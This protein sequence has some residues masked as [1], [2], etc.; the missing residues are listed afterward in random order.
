MQVYGA[1][2][3]A[4]HIEENPQLQAAQNQQRRFMP[5]PN[6]IGGRMMRM[7]GRR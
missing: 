2:W 6:K 4:L 5:P 7:R 3:F 1:D